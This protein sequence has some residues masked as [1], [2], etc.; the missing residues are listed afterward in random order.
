MSKS[1]DTVVALLTGLSNIVLM[2][3]RW[4]VITLAFLVA[5]VTA[6]CGSP[7]ESDEVQAELVTASPM[8]VSAIGRLEPQDG[9]IAI[10]ASSV[11]E[12]T[13]GAI[14]T[15]LLVDVGDDVEVGELLAVTDTAAVLEAS[16]EEARTELAVAE[17]RAD[18]AR[19]SADAICVRAGVLR[20]EAERLQSLM[21]KNLAAEEETDRA[22]GAAA[23]SAADCTAAQS[24]AKVAVS[25]IAVANARMHR[26]QIEFERSNIHAP[27][28]GKILAI[29]TRP[30]ERI[31]P[32]AILELGRVHRMLAIAEVYEADIGRLRIG[33]QATISSAAL[34]ASITGHIERI[35][36]L[37][38][39][40][41]QIGTDPAAR[42][43]ARIVEVEV[44]LDAPESVA[45]LTHLQVDVQFDP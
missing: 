29:T 25:G 4:L 10:S 22:L 42:K 45:T 26:Q 19:S 21:A 15:R 28:S 7:S 37:V 20:R 33:Q 32:Q 44:L 30:G 35:R 41:G 18:A 5:T 40:Q 14:L 13:A 2:S 3:G 38:H 39:K 11:P 8:G 9:I 6:G 17:Q 16:V 43:D 23:A 36:P 34:P 27:V 31:G 1:R 12:A 24:A